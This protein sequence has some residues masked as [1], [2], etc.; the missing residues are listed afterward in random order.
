VNR[1]IKESA[2]EIRS[3]VVVT[4]LGLA[5]FAHGQQA[6]QWRVEDGGNGH[7]YRASLVHDWFEAS[8]LASQLGTQL[9]A[10]NSL[11]EN[12]FVRNLLGTTNAFRGYIGLEQLPSQEAPNLGWRWVNNEPLGYSNWTDFGGSF[13]FV[14]PD[15]TPCNLPPIYIE[16]GQADIAMIDLDGRWD[17]L[18]R[19]QLDCN[20]PWIHAAILEWSADCNGDGIVDYGQILDGS[21]FDGDSN[22]VPDCCEIGYD[23][24]ENL[25]QNG[26]FEAGPSQAD[27]TWV[28]VGP[29]STNLAPWQVTQSNVDRVRLSTTCG[30][31]EVWRSFE[32]EFTV[33]LDGYWVA[34][35][36]KQSVSTTI[37]HRYRLTLRMTGNCEAGGTEFARVT[38]GDAS[39]EITH[40]CQPGWPQ[41]WAS[42]AFTFE[43]VSTLTEIVIESLSTSGGGGVVIDDV[44]MTPIDDQCP[45]D[46]TGGGVVDAIDLAAILG[47]WGT[48]GQGK[49]DSDINDD[50]TVDAQDLAIVL[51]GW[52]NCP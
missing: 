50:G 13:S 23:C 51:G 25:I 10:I 38:A 27:C 44:R 5:S 32:G 29:G 33:D 1:L 17:D 12:Q 21:L 19:G 28:I 36:I 16:D 15:D 49:F 22:G 39:V 18:E 41:P 24:F 7:W 52:G 43:A 45:G 40:D 48:S 42:T 35:R 4:A 20:V 6:V 14:A 2:M 11:A 30:P 3:V 31:V 9:V 8:Q 37:G 26:G 47:A 46:I 34:G